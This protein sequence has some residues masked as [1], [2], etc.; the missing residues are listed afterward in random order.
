MCEQVSHLT[1][2]SGSTSSRCFLLLPCGPMRGEYCQHQPIRGGITCIPVSTNCP[3]CWLSRTKKSPSYL[4]S[5]SASFLIRGKMFYSF[6]Q[7]R[8]DNTLKELMNYLD[9]GP[10]NHSSFDRIALCV[11]RLLGCCEGGMGRPGE[12]IPREGEI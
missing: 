11:I 1:T 3:G 4:S 12:G 5:C 2:P 10:W 8:R 6:C 7:P 9:I